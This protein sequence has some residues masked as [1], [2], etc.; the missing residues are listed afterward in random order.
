MHFTWRQN[1]DVTWF[2]E[3]VLL[4]I[5]IELFFIVNMSN[6]CAKMRSEVPALHKGNVS[7]KPTYPEQTIVYN[8]RHQKLSEYK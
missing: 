3:N 1:I 2:I 6:I 4:S 5:G 7:S 8:N